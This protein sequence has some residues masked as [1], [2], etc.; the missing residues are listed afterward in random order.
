MGR[1]GWGQGRGVRREKE[2]VAERNSRANMA[3]EEEKKSDRALVSL[4]LSTL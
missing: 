3:A 2:R 4:S 1:G